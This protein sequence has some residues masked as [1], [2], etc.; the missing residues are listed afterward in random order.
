MTGNPEPPPP[1]FDPATRGGHRVTRLIYEGTSPAGGAIDD[2]L[3]A[4]GSSRDTA[5][6]WSCSDAPKA[7]PQHSR[8]LPGEASAAATHRILTA[9][10]DIFDIDEMMPSEHGHFV[11]NAHGRVVRRHGAAGPLEGAGAA[12]AAHTRRANGARARVFTAMRTRR[13]SDMIS[14]YIHARTHSH[15]CRCSVID[16]RRRRGSE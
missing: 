16:G 1:D 5:G 7:P 2:W 15:T 4:R 14:M 13:I 6:F 10:G 3:M 8:A 11:P 12:D 9:A